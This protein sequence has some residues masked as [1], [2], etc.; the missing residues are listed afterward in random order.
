M[1]CAPTCARER[2]EGGRERRQ[3]CLNPNTFANYI[4]LACSSHISPTVTDLSH[5]FESA[6]KFV[7]TGLSKWDTTS[8]TNLNFTFYR[9]V[10]MNV[11]LGGWS[12][13]KGE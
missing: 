8:V 6:E 7:G 11:N 4:S 2:E 3:K 12:V 5:A 1:L 10:S 9:A 13:A